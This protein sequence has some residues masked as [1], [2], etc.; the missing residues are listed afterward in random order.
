MEKAISKHLGEEN[1]DTIAGQLFHVHARSSEPI[2][3]ADGYTIHA[4]HHNDFAVAVIPKHFRNHDQIQARHVAP[5][6]GRAGSF[7]HQVQFIVKVFVKL[8]H[9]FTRL[10]AFAIG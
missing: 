3:L 2:R 4:L 6:L 5:Q 7:A 8:G 9:H 10:Q 1:G